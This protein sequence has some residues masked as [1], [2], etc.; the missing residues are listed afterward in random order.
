MLQQPPRFEPQLLPVL[1]VVTFKQ[2]Q[3]VKPPEFDGSTDPIKAT[4]WLKEIE[5][6]FALV[7]ICEDQKTDF[8]SYLL[9]GEA[10]YWWESKNALEGEDVIAWIGLK[11]CF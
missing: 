10:N 7:K 3:S 4:T 11:S 2:F 5:K 1:P 8:A 9:K 6:A